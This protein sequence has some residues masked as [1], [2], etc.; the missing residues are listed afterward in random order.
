MIRHNIAIYNSSEP[1][2]QQGG[3]ER[4]TDSVARLLAKAGH[5]VTLLYRHPNRLGVHYDAP[6]DILKIT[7]RKDFEDA[8]TSRDIDIVIDQTEGEIIGRYGIYPDKKAV[9]L[10]CKFAAVQHSSA[11]TIFNNY[12]QVFKL[13]KSENC[14]PTKVWLYNKLLLPIRKLHSLHHIKSTFKDISR[15]YD[16]VVTLSESFIKDFTDICPSADIRKIHAIPN[17]NTYVDCPTTEGLSKVLF[18]GRLQNDAKGVDRLLRIWS[19]VEPQFPNW[20]LDIV[21]DGPDKTFN[22]EL[23]QKL[24]LRNIAF[25]GY[26]DPAPFY[27]R[28]SVFCMTSNYEGFGMV[29]TEAMQHGVVPMAFNSYSSA[30]DIIDDGKCGILVGPFTE[31]EYAEK[32]SWLLSD[33]KMRKRMSSCAIEKARKFSPEAIVEKWNELFETL[34]A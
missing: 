26:A 27:R 20:S 19:K 32:L 30:P 10:K 33:E 21:G 4:V 34:F 12:F 18:V 6:V 7:C 14:S 15:N 3:M 2:P 22:E 13:R 1:L 23:A 28:A 24:R 9:G 8:I 25:H 31:D 17:P 11:K 29:L 5:T 16:A